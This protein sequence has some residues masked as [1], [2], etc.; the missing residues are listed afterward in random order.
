MQP[1]T[2]DFKPLRRAASC[3]LLRVLFL[4]LPLCVL[5]WHR[6]TAWGAGIAWLIFASLTC[7]GGPVS[8]FLTWSFWTPF[9]RLT[10]G[11]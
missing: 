4:L 7:Q 3:L 8:R 10:Y 2:I 6:R 1:L 5:L 11:W 9:A